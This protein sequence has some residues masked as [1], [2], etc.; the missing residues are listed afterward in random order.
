[1]SCLGLSVLPGLGSQPP[2]P[3]EGRIP[4]ISASVF[5]GSFSFPSRVLKVLITQSCLTLCNPMD[6]SPPGSSVHRILQARALEWVAVPFSSS[7]HPRDHTQGSRIAGRFSVVWATREDFSFENSYNI[8]VG[9]LKV[10]PGSLRLSLFLFILFF[11]KF[12]SA[13]VTATVLSSSSLIHLPPQLLDYW[14][15][16][17]Y[18]SFQLLY[19]SSLVCTSFQF[20]WNPWKDHPY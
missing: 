12:C 10:F 2:F 11:F 8:N 3:C 13:A 4:M 17:V 20:C 16:P 15:F 6:C 5:S 18:I 9:S 14:L 7:P 19:C 1:M